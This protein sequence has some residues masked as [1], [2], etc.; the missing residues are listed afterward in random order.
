MDETK[1]KTIKII[2]EKRKVPK[3][4]TE[5]L[6]KFTKMKKAILKI[7]KEGRKTP[8]E[9]AKSLNIPTD[10]AFY[11]LM[12]LQKYGFVE[13]DEIDDMDEYFYYKLK[14]ND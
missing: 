5:N 14:N 13:V 12:T 3:E 6:K 11:N 7:L 1:R 8:P 10:E 9:L 2:K 4:V